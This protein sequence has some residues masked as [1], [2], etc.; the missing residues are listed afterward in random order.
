MIY[1]ECLLNNV[2]NLW[3]ETFLISSAHGGINELFYI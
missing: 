1:I 2:E 3:W